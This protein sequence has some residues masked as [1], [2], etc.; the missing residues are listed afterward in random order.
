MLIESHYL[1]RTGEDRIKEIAGLAGTYGGTEEIALERISDEKELLSLS[2]TPAEAARRYAHGDLTFV[3]RFQGDLAA[4]LWACTDDCF[5]KG[6]GVSIPCGN[7]GSY[8]YN[9]YVFPEYR[10]NKFLIKLMSKYAMYSLGRNIKEMFA[11]VLTTNDKMN[12]FMDKYFCKEKSL[13]KITLLNFRIG[14][15]IDHIVK[16]KYIYIFNNNICNNKYWI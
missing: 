14:L 12:A 1:Y 3:A 10:R 15:K 5:I 9:V 6:V 7:A 16:T 2:V 11:L 4:V 8:F 13:Y